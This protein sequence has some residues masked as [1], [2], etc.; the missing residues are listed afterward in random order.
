MARFIPTPEILNK[1]IDITRKK[2]N[3]QKSLTKF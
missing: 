3:L 1:L 2:I